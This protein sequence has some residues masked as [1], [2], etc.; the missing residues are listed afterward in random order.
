MSDL[1]TLDALDATATEQAL[2][3]VDEFLE[4]A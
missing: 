2:K 4:A 1:V 3:L